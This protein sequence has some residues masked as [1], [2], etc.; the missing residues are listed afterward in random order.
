LRDC[1][2]SVAKIRNGYTAKACFGC[3]ALRCE[4]YFGRQQEARRCGRQLFMLPPGT[5]LVR[6]A[7]WGDDR[8]A[9]L[10]FPRI[11]AHLHPPGPLRH[12]A[13]CPCPLW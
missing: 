1:K 6:G 10:P 8:A 5:R 9:P 2:A 11:T 7:H 13:L 3:H 4:M 12:C